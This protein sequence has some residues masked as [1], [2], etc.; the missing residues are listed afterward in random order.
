MIVVCNVVVDVYRTASIH[1]AVRVFDD[2][3]AFANAPKL[4]I[5]FIGGIRSYLGDRRILPSPVCSL[6]SDQS[7]R[8]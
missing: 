5:N 7:T 1:P 3:Y 2:A 8:I 6:N 4:D